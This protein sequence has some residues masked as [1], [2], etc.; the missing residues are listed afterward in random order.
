MRR[1]RLLFG[2]ALVA[3]C[4]ASVF[5][6]AAASH[7]SAAAQGPGGGVNVTPPNKAKP[8]QQ[9]MRVGRSYNNDISRS[10]RELAKLPTKPQPQREAAEN[11]TIHKVQRNVTDPVVQSSPANPKM[12]GTLQNFDGIPFPGVVCN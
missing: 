10:A 9:G 2:G 5:L 4:L 11:A 6:A 7:G 12:P 3:L 8:T 1:R